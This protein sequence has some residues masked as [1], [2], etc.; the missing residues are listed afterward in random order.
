[1]TTQKMSRFY[2]RAAEGMT[3][4]VDPVGVVNV[5]FIYPTFDVIIGLGYKE[6]T[7]PSIFPMRR[8]ITSNEFCTLF[9]CSINN[10]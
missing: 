6:S 2:A 3:P 5:I 4:S 1:M 9:H 8:N 7:C 10:T